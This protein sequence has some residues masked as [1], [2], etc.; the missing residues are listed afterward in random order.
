MPKPS[1]LSKHV[2]KLVRIHRK[3]IDAMHLDAYVLAVSDELALLQPVRDRIDL[4]GY[5]VIRLADVSSVTASPRASFYEEALALKRMRPTKPKQLSL[6]NMASLLKSVN[7]AYPLVV[8]HR[9]SVTPDSCEIGRVRDISDRT[10]HLDWINPNAS[11]EKDGRRFRLADITRIQF[12]G[13]YENA[14]A[15]VARRHGRQVRGGRTKA[16]R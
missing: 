8:I 1:S 13:A 10:Y 5:D 7:E 9:E 12:D 6:D 15:M 2:G 14:L 16:R 3:P 11:F 4:D